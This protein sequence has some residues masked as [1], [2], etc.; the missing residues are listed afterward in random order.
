MVI[1]N[2]KFSHTILSSVMHNATLNKLGSIQRTELQFLL[3]RNIRDEMLFYQPRKRFRHTGITPGLTSI[4]K[5]STP[6]KPVHSFSWVIQNVLCSCYGFHL[7]WKK[8]HYK[9]KQLLVY[10]AQH[11]FYCKILQISHLIKQQHIK[12]ML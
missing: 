8:V 4:S 9:R 12:Y 1:L 11:E 10:K 2:F 3:W 7:K 6:L 5:I